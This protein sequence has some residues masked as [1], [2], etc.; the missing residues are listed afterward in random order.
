MSLNRLSS[1]RVVV[2]A[3]FSFTGS[4]K[5]IWHGLVWDRTPRAAWSALAILLIAMAWFCVLGWYLTWG[6]LLVPY[7]LIRRSG[8][9][10][11]LLEARH[12]ELLGDRS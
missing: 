2:E 7:R 12:R 1:E 11:V 10:R 5:R 6:L 8:R 9:R 3:P 4:A